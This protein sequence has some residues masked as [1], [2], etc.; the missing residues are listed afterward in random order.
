M[1][2]HFSFSG[3]LGK[4]R[5]L[6]L[7]PPLN[8]TDFMKLLA[9]SK[10]VITDSGGIQSEATFL[11]IPCLTLR[12]TLEKPETIKLGTVTLCGLDSGFVMKKVKEILKGR[13]KIGR[14]PP[15]MDGKAGERIGKVIMGELNSRKG[16]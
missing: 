1:F 2:T 12:D 13:Y 14:T 3:R 16:R 7:A 15:L 11:G 6:K 5:N 9:E 10:F 8:Y 4:I